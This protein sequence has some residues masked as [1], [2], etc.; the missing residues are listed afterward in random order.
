MKLKLIIF[1]FIVFVTNKTL[2]QVGINTTSPEAQFDIRS[3]N[4]STPANTDGILI[5]KIDSFPAT[6]PTALQQGMLVYLTTTATFASSSRTPGFYYWDNGTANWIGIQSS[7]R[8]DW[9]ILGNANTNPATHFLGTTDNQDIVFRR[10]NIRAGYIGD[11]TYDGGFNFNNGNTSFGANSMLNPTINFGTQSGVRNTAFGVNVMPSLTTGRLNVGVG[12]FALF[13]NTSGI[14]NTAIGSGALYS[15]S[16]ANNNVAIGRNALTTSNSDNNTA[17][18]FAALRQN[19]SGTNN[20]ALGYEALRNVLGSGN[21]GIGYQAGR[22]ETGSNKLYIENSNADASN[23]LIYGEFDN[24]ILRTNGTLQIGNPTTT[25]YSFPTNRGTN[26]QFLQTDGAGITTWATVPVN[27]IKPYT[28]TGAATGIYNV[29]LTEYTIRV[30]GG[31]SEIRLPNAIGNA[32]KVFI[33]IGSNGIGAKIFSTLGGIIYDDVT[34][35]ILNTLNANTRYMV[36]S[37]GADWIVIGN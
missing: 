2:A 30:F 1:L 32:G 7:E 37:D 9:N 31:V 11:P 16:S 13:S 8:I 24:N 10:F 5:P 6:N 29:S 4:Q 17:V 27:T 20:T 3:S 35:T 25:G 19:V 18:G 12:E 26:G 33:I 28:T 15:N 14:T 23:A 36:Q 21:V 22:L 34:N